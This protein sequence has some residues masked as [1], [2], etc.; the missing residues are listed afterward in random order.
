MK[1]ARIIDVCDP[2]AR[3]ANIIDPLGLDDDIPL[4]EVLP[5]IWPTVGDLRKL[6]DELVKLGWTNNHERR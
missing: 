3:A 4:R 6:R 2:F 1:N 5:G